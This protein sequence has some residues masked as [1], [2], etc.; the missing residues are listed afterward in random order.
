MKMIQCKFHGGNVVGAIRE[1]RT[2]EVEA[3]PRAYASRSFPAKYKVRDEVLE[4]YKEEAHN[5]S[6]MGVRDKKIPWHAKLDPG[7][8]FWVQEAKIGQQYGVCFGR[9]EYNHDYSNNYWVILG[10]EVEPSGPGSGNKQFTNA[11]RLSL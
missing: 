5:W 6:L 4:I 1:T 10:L 11:E 9:I 8:E 2:C 3:K 7:K